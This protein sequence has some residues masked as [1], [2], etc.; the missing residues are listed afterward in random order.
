MSRSPNTSPPAPVAVTEIKCFDGRMDRLTPIRALSYEESYDVGDFKVEYVCHYHA[1]RNP[2]TNAE[3]QRYINRIGRTVCSVL[4]QDAK[5]AQGKLQQAGLT[6]TSRKEAMYVQLVNKLQFHLDLSEN[7][8]ISTHAAGD[9]RAD[10]GTSENMADPLS[11]LSIASSL[12]TVVDFASK[13]VKG[14]LELRRSGNA[15]GVTKQEVELVALDFAALL[16]R[17]QKRQQASSSP[18]SEDETALKDLI[19]SANGLLEELLDALR[20]LKPSKP[21]RKWST[22]RAALGAVWNE[23]KIRSYVQRLSLLQTSLATKLVSIISSVDNLCNHFKNIDLSGDDEVRYLCQKIKGWASTST[24]HSSNLEQQLSDV[25]KRIDRLCTEWHTMTKYD[26]LVK[27]LQVKELR[28]REMAIDPAHAQTFEWALTNK[29]RRSG[30]ENPNDFFAWLRH[31]NGLFWI[32]GKAGSARHFLWQAGTTLQKSQRGLLQNILS[33]VLSQYPRLIPK[34]CM[35]VWTALVDNDFG[36]IP[37]RLDCALWS[38]Q[39]LIQAFEALQATDLDNLRFCIFIDGL[40]EYHGD[41][42]DIINVVFK[43]LECPSIKICASSRPWNDFYQAFEG[44]PRMVLEDLTSRDISTYVQAKLDS[45]RR[46]RA[47]RF[48][49]DRYNLLVKEIV[50]RAHGVFLWVHLV[51]RSLGRGLTNHDTIGELR[52]RL[53]EIPDD[54]HEWFRI[55]LHSIDKTYAAQSARL[56]QLLLNTKMYMDNSAMTLSFF[57]EEGLGF[58]LRTP[59]EP[60]SDETLLQWEHEAAVRIRARCKDLVVVNTLLGDEAPA[61]YLFPTLH[62]NFLHRTV[63]DF[64][65]EEDVQSFLQKHMTPTRPP[66]EE[67]F[68]ASYLAQVKMLA[69][70]PFSEKSFE[71]DPLSGFQSKSSFGQSLESLLESCFWMETTLSRPCSWILDNLNSAVLQNIKMHMTSGPTEVES[72]ACVVQLAMDNYL[73]LYLQERMQSRSVTCCS[74]TANH[75]TRLLIGPEGRVWKSWP[76]LPPLCHEAMSRTEQ[77]SANLNLLRS[78][79]ENG[80]GPNDPV[81]TNKTCGFLSPNGYTEFDTIWTYFFRRHNQGDPFLGDFFDFLE[82]FLRKGADPHVRMTWY[83]P[84]EK[85]ALSFTIGLFDVVETWHGAEGI[86]RLESLLVKLGLPKAPSYR[87]NN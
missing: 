71:F 43:L 30:N 17:L 27:S 45:H 50:R 84:G 23:K 7:D 85:Q 76:P 72:E 60:C 64:L 31:G 75:L 38:M 6:P 19:T 13:I 81:I 35:S 82:L 21:Y 42:V 14:T 63:R 56:L 69:N 29:E 40:D 57:S 18:K 33:Q 55:M 87:L 79:F 70:N 68:A 54:L 61:E 73:D 9:T 39:D 49:D 46:F 2:T 32:V 78:L 34:V 59:T 8:P 37:G 20:K 5:N 74:P 62:V 51:M 53:D 11:G 48:N 1:S 36:I 86:Y 77:H 22:M 52:N 4:A 25:Q 65:L 12:I 47:M 83:Y 66:S 10:Q 24:D 58:A 28:S 3:R 67:Y 16:D 15:G 44:H 41:H 26:Y 80:A